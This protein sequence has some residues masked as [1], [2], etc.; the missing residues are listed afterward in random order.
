M[1]VDICCSSLMG[2]G[3]LPPIF[4]P[5]AAASA[6]YL[7]G[8]LFRNE[9]SDS[10]REAIAAARDA[11]QTCGVSVDA[12]RVSS[13]VDICRQALEVCGETTQLLTTISA[14]SADLASKL[15]LA[16]Q[17]NK[18]LTVKVKLQLGLIGFLI[19]VI[20]IL[21]IYILKGIKRGIF[22]G[23]YLIQATTRWTS[24][25]R[26]PTCS[27]CHRR[28]LSAPQRL[29]ALRRGPLRPSDRR[30]LHDGGL[31]AEHQ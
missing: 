16:E 3:S 8:A 23:Y 29:P 30:L 5:A 14:S 20:G 13:G 21:V 4:A 15:D 22:T 31:H 1:S 7:A 17:E 27:L 24:R 18:R 19:F 2:A 9:I 26:C 25:I 28:A 10:S 6:G 11:L 12:L